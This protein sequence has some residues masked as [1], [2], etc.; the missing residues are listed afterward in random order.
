MIS[1]KTNFDWVISI[2]K[3][4]LILVFYEIIYN[5]F[6]QLTMQ[7]ILNARLWYMGAES[8]FVWKTIFFGNHSF[9]EIKQ[10]MILP[11]A[12]ENLSKSSIP[13]IL[14]SKLKK[15]QRKPRK[16]YSYTTGLHTFKTKLY[17]TISQFFE[18]FVMFEPLLSFTIPLNWTK[19]CCSIIDSNRW[20]N[21]K[22]LL[23]VV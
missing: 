22:I 7:Y 5:R 8:S 23:E 20:R 13:N 10:K 19:Y 16:L 12:F 15:N 6:F 14:H 9:Y 11:H 2:T 18:Q 3:L 21:N 17:C 1:W 4:V